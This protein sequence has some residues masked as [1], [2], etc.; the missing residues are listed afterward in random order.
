[1]DVKIEASWKQVLAAEFA[2]AY[3]TKITE[4]IKADIAQGISI[5]PKGR[6]MFNAFTY[7][8]WHNTKVI[9]IGQDPYHG[10][11]QAHGL[12]FSVPH[13]LA[14]PPSLVNIYK[15]LNA[16]LGIPTPAHGNL[17][18]WAQQGVL[19]LNTSLTVQ[20]GL[21]M[22]HSKIGWEQFTDAVIQQL[23]TYKQHL[24]FVLWGAF[25]QKKSILIDASKH[26]I[27]KA[28]H[29]SPLS[30][31]NGFYGCKHFSKINEYLL[32]HQQQAINWV[33]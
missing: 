11:G 8:T 25:A 22:S 4:R 3:F 31:Y 29:P 7:S 23:S 17:M 6:D 10:T 18:A 24:V 28:A 30:A 26:L 32:A 20:A 33:L 9:I 19:L 5:Y 16:D 13:G 27:L 1:M 2:K 14:I 12:S 15:E 21:P